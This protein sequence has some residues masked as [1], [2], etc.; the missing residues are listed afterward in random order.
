MDNKRYGTRDGLSV[1]TISLN[2]G[3]FDELSV[4]INLNKYM[5]LSGDKVHVTHN[6][7]MTRKGARKQDLLRYI[8]KRTSEVVN[9]DTIDL[10]YLNISRP[11]YVDT[12]DVKAFIGKAIEYGVFRDDY[13]HSL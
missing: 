3:N 9:G 13:K 10:G 1:L 5:R 12:D 8:E 4:Q 6:G 11:L 2:D 7:A